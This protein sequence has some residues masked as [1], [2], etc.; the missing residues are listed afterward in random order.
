MNQLAF[1]DYCLLVSWHVIGAPVRHHNM[2]LSL[3]PA[4]APASN[5]NFLSHQTPPRPHSRALIKVHD[6]SPA[7]M[8]QGSHLRLQDFIWASAPPANPSSVEATAVQNTS[9]H[10]MEDVA[11]AVSGL[12]ISSLQDF[13]S[14]SGIP[15]SLPISA[16]APMHGL[17]NHAQRTIVSGL[18]GLC[19]SSPRDQGQRHRPSSSAPISP[20]LGPLDSASAEPTPTQSYIGRTNT[21]PSS[22][23]R[24][25]LTAMR[26][27]ARKR[28]AADCKDLD[29][30]VDE[31]RKFAKSYYLS[32]ETLVIA[33]LTGQECQVQDLGRFA[34]L[35]SGRLEA[36]GRRTNMA[37]KG[38]R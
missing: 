4:P 20:S 17:Q 33:I 30:V 12:H 38:S 2:K 34:V 16:A 23:R 32:L 22:D 36:L 26:K 3:I 31:A 1:N 35:D 9:R 24:R 7:I 18:S 15:R 14:I 10:D 28:R 27:K 25:R 11:T 6:S 19:L 37:L 29:T 13:I 21:T 8:S 5:W